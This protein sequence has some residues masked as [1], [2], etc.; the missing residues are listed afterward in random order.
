MKIEQVEPVRLRKNGATYR[1]KCWV[2][3]TLKNVD[4]NLMIKKL[5]LHLNQRTSTS[6][7]VVRLEVQV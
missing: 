3:Y 1:Q 4:Q 7:D 5:P 6:A 2:A